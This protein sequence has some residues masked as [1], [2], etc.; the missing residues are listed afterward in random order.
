M[1]ERNTHTKPLFGST[2]TFLAPDTPWGSDK[3]T[4]DKVAGCPQGTHTHTTLS[5]YSFSGHL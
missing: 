1:R 5:S 4:S 3:V 2:G